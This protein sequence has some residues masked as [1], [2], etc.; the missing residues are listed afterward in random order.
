M[1]SS[2][3]E[4]HIKKIFP[5]VCLDFKIISTPSRLEKLITDI[6]MKT[7]FENFYIDFSRVID[8]KNHVYR[9]T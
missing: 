6:T 5:H 1:S 4:F 7:E 9:N 3:T 2:F 8:L